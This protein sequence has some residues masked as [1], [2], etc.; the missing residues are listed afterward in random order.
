MIRLKNMKIRTQLFLLIFAAGLFCFLLYNFMWK[1]KWEVYELL[2]S[3]SIIRQHVLPGPRDDLWLTIRTEA[4]KYDIPESETDKEGNKAI[5]PFFELADPYTAVY[6]YGIEDGLYRAGRIPSYFDTGSSAFFNS[7]YQWTDGLGEY[8]QDLVV[9][10]KNGY[11][12]VIVRFLHPTFF[13]TPYFFFCFGLC[14]T[15][16]FVIILF[17]I[18]RKMNSVILL[19]QKI[20]QMAAGDLITPVPKLRQD[21]IGIL[22]H[23]LDSLRV[24]LHETITKEQESRLANQDLISALSHDLR[25][26]LTILNGYLEIA[27]LNQKPEMQEE[28]LNRC[29]N[30]TDEIRQMTDRIFEYALVYEEAELPVLCDLPVSALHRYLT[31]NADFLRLTGFPVSLELPK[32]LT[33]PGQITEPGSQ[34]SAYFAGDE[35]LLTRIFNNLFSNIIK[36]GSKKEPVIITGS[37]EINHISISLFNIVKQESSGIESTQIGL[38]SVRKMMELMDGTLETEQQNAEFTVR[39]KLPVYSDSRN[40]CFDR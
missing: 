37:I 8:E 26:P 30:K 15:V 29:L 7:L 3:S 5:A 22:A 17:F 36:Y 2:Q 11:A 33:S 39:L 14:I 18:S 21:E 35:T 9:E 40:G 16:F 25:T 1:Y 31:E 4:L 10:F 34:N 6:I 23:E 19:K 20:L 38:K 27:K 24:A 13:V 28:Y 32:A 12:Q